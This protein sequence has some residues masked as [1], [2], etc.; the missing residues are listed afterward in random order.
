MKKT[1]KLF[2]VIT[3][4]STLLGCFDTR[5]GGDQSLMRDDVKTTTYELSEQTKKE[6]EEGKDKIIIAEFFYRERSM[7]MTED[8]VTTSIV[9]TVNA[10]NEK[11]EENGYTIISLDTTTQGD[12]S[13]AISF[14]AIFSK[15]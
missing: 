2:L 7:S 11:M 13:R 12:E 15:K 6:I 9:E 10:M 3:L 8:S 1:G 5:R 4:V 14:I